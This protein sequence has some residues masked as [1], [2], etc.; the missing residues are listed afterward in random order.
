MTTLRYVMDSYTIVYI[1][2]IILFTVIW[3]QAASQFFF[4]F[5]Y[6]YFIAYLDPREWLSSEHREYYYYI[7]LCSIVL[8]NFSNLSHIL[9]KYL[10]LSFSITPL[11][12]YNIIFQHNISIH[13]FNFILVTNACKVNK[14]LSVK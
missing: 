14:S 12:Q 3:L 10:I 8:R 7:L 6:V 1:H 13:Q 4:F 2:I 9:P 11:Y 5:I